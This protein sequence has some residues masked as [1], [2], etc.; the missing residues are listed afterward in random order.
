[1]TLRITDA[2]LNKLAERM[3][4]ATGSPKEPWTIA[5]PIHSQNGCFHIEHAYGGVTLSRMSGTA[6]ATNNV[7]SCGYVTK[8]QLAESMHAWLLGYLAC[9]KEWV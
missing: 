7:F 8:R 3:N 1:M 5:V 4:E 6:G 9:R 2:M